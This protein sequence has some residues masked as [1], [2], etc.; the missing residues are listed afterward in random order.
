MMPIDFEY[1]LGAENGSHSMTPRV[2]KVK[3]YSGF[4]TVSLSIGYNFGVAKATAVM[5]EE[6]ALAVAAALVEAAGAGM[7]VQVRETVI[8][9]N[10]VSP[11]KTGHS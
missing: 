1:V 6:Q 2:V 4:D 11:L 10:G 3:R 9:N 8:A 7:R 5:N